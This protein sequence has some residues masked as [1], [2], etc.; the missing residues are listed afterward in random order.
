[1]STIKYR[2]SLAADLQRE[3]TERMIDFYDRE[4]FYILCL[5]EATWKEKF[6]YGTK[7]NTSPEPCVLSTKIWQKVWIPVHPFQ[8]VH[9]ANSRICDY[10]PFSVVKSLLN[11]Q[12]KPRKQAENEGRTFL[13]IL[14]LVER[15]QKLSHSQEEWDQCTGMGETNNWLVVEAG[16]SP[17]PSEVELL[18]RIGS[19]P[20][21]GVNPKTPVIRQREFPHHSQICS[22]SPLRK[23]KVSAK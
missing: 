6:E 18:L 16:D 11:F 7:R 12:T 9:Q 13:E 8:Y 21:Y 22:L 1:M 4:P 10:I 19:Y 23:M 3:E 2:P 17:L 20:V 5:H 14:N 15:L